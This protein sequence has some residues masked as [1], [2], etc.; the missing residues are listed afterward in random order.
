VKRSVVAL[1]VL[2]C[3]LPLTACS[4]IKNKK[5]TA[6][7]KDKVWAEIKNSNDLTVEEVGLL[8]GYVIRH[9]LKDAFSGKEVSLPEG[10]T[11]GEMIEEQRKFVEDAKV[12]EE[13]E[14]QRRE[15]AKAEAD[16]R[17]KALLDALIITVYDKGFQASDY[18]EGVYDDYITIELAYEN[19]T[20]KDIR[21]FKGIV[22]FNDLFGDE[23]EKLQLKEDRIVKAGQTL[24]VAKTIDYNQFKDDDKKLR[25]TTLENMKIEW[26][27]DTI[28]FTDG[29]S[30]KVNEE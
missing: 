18:T 23:I 24:K 28:M 27:P 2:I 13:E 17:R 21:G 3:L 30:L 6:E 29:T 14:K 8:Q 20:T 5:V 10:K 19:H 7:N 1:L 22:V 4:N 25:S 12:R 16:Q 26:V 9:G 11:I 15:K